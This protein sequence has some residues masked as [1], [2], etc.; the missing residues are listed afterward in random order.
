MVLHQVVLKCMGLTA[1]H[2]CKLR[3]GWA[4][5]LHSNQL[6]CNHLNPQFRGYCFYSQTLQAV[7]VFLTWN[8][9]EEEYYNMLRCPGHPQVMQ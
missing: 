6:G 5:A 1:L 2:A 4:R 8:V 9:H 7:R 3:Q